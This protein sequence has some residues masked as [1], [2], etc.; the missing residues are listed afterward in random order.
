MNKQEFKKAMIETAMSVGLP[1]I[2]DYNCCRLLAWLYVYGGENEQVIQDNLS[3]FIMYAQRR[4]N[5]FG[6][7]IPDRKLLPLLQGYI[8]SITDYYNP[9]EW[10]IELEKKYNI[11][12]HRS[13]L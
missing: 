7:E 2:S 3:F 11:K 9:P 8:E 13:K 1:I 10:V 6:G 12:P 4:L 5:I